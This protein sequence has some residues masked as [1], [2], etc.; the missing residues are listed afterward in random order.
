MNESFGKEFYRKEKSVKRSG[1][2]SEPFSAPRPSRVISA[3]NFPCFTP[4]LALNF[5]EI[6]RVG[7]P[8][9]GKHSTR[10]LSPDFMPHFTTPLA[11]K[12]REN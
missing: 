10:K 11:E 2:S 9:P 1:P 8:N 5:G 7:H 6:F 12:N 4:F 3:Q